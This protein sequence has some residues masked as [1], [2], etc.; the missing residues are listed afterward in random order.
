MV[1]VEELI[2]STFVCWVSVEGNEFLV[3]SESRYSDCIV[4]LRC[5]VGWLN[6]DWKYV[7]QEFN[8]HGTQGEAWT[9]GKSRTEELPCEAGLNEE[10]NNKR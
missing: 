4:V 7:G 2:K 1:K 3:E 8:R 9:L 5:L 10:K 6:L